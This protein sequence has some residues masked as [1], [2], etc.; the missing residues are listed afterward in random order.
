MSEGQDLLPDGE[1]QI[2]SV[3]SWPRILQ[4]E[5]LGLVSTMRRELHRLERATHPAAEFE[6]VPL[7]WQEKKWTKQEGSVMSETDE[8]MERLE[9]EMR[10]LRGWILLLSLALIATF[11]VGATQGTPDELALRRLAIVDG[12]GKERIVAATTSDGH[13]AVQH[14]DSDGKMRIAAGTLPDGHAAVQHFDRNG[15]NES[16]QKRHRTA[17]RVLITTTATGR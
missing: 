15:S 16:A 14:Y 10:R 13:A 5:P 7:Q 12:D 3:E 11:A 8:R 4:R 9:R 6:I 1:K 17:M 2:P